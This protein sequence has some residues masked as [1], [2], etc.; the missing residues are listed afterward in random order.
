[1]GTYSSIP[2][3]RIPWT[4]EPGGLYSPWGPKESDM[5]EATYAHSLQKAGERSSDSD[6]P[7]ESENMIL[8]SWVRWKPA[9]LEPW[10]G[11]VPFSIW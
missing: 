10:S 11:L 6:G 9:R 4:E 7:P 3:W 2:G 1:M 5:T 8:G